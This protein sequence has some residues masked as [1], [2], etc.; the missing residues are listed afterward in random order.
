MTSCICGEPD[1]LGNLDSA[2]AAIVTAAARTLGISNTD[3][4][5]SVQRFGA[6][7]NYINIFDTT[8]GGIGL[9]IAISERLKE[10]LRVAVQIATECP[11]CQPN[12]SCYAC[13]RS[14]ANQRRHDHLCRA[15]AG[16]VVLALL[17]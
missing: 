4:N 17:Q 1:C 2:A 3:L 14:Y 16:E 9:T 15:L 8:P 12:S 5:A 6:D 7:A 11:N 13:L 10:I